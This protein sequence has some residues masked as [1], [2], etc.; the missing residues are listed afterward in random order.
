MNADRLIRRI[1]RRRRQ[2]AELQ[3][4]IVADAQTLATILDWTLSTQKRLTVR[5]KQMLLLVRSG[6]SNKEIASKINRSERTVKF[7]VGNLLRKYSTLNRHSLPG[8]LGWIRGLMEE[9]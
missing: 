4:G 6:L 1:R 8:G 7:H 9:K 2:I 5:E 3:A